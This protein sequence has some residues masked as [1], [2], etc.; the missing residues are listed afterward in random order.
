MKMRSGSPPVCI[1]T[2]VILIQY[3]GGCQSECFKSSVMLK[4]EWPG[5]SANN[6]QDEPAR[7]TLLGRASPSRGPDRGRQNNPGLSSL[8]GNR[9]GIRNAQIGI[10]NKVLI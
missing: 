3:D 1:S 7:L 2:V 8:S 4:E 6:A 5:R 10:S 9:T